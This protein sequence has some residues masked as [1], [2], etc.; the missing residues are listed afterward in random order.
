MCAQSAPDVGNA[1]P[2]AR[3]GMIWQGEVDGTAFL[4][5][6]GKRLTIEN[7]E[8]APVAKQNY[9][10]EQR[11][12][13]T[14]Q[15]VRLHVTAGRGYVH[16]VEQPRLENDFT[17]AIA[18]EDPQPGSGFY[19]LA[20]YWDA[21]ASAADTAGPRRAGRLQWSGRVD[22]EVIVSCAA[23]QCAS[24]A[25]QGLPVMR[26]HVKFSSPLPQG[27]APVRLEKVDGRGD[28][29]VL[30]QPSE[31]NG[32]TARVQ[33]RDPQPGVAEYSFALTWPHASRQIENA[34]PLAPQTGL[35]WSGRVTGIARVTV[36]GGAAFSEVIQGQPVAQE[37]AAFDRPLPSSS[38][39]PVLTKRQ[40]VGSVDIVDY[41]SDRNGY[42][43]TFEIRGGQRGADLYEVEVAW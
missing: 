10:V 3:P 21:G 14:R 32:Y 28:V 24:Q 20:L 26:E 17:V 1:A 22:Q 4:Y 11:L 16:I 7:K 37:H 9:R 25:R 5:L 38:L 30:E 13:E 27:E 15:D 33:I 36:R 42:C 12:P 35:V 39:K 18:I 40:G 6:K 19:S 8:G 23:S 29:R 31:A 34:V 43:L 2:D 41:P